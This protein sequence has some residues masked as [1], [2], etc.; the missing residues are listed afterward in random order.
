VTPVLQVMTLVLLG[1]TAVRLVLTDEYLRFVKPVLAPWLLL[2]GG[3]LVLLGLAVN[4]LIMKASDDDPGHG[5][6]GPRVGLLLLL[7]V[8][9][10]YVVAPPALGSFAAERTAS[11]EPAQLSDGTQYVPLP[12]PDPDGYRTVTLNEYTSR[13]FWK[14]EPNFQGERV[15]MVGFVTP[16]EGQGWLLTRMQIACCAADGFPIK[17]LVR[18]AED[19]PRDT[20]VRLEGR[21]VATASD[22]L[23][24]DGILGVVDAERVTPIEVP[25]EPYE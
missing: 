3:A 16:Y 10:V 15:R 18:G 9:V 24:D 22:E 8:A 23:V 25:T 12:E 11:R 21:G 6:T 19:L 5:H 13:V 1:A 17:V 4:Y 20:W 7:P 14:V 2:V